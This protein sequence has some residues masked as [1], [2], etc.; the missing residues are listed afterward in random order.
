LTF[1][2]KILLFNL[3]F[4]DFFVHILLHRRRERAGNADV[5]G[6]SADISGK[7]ADVFCISADI[8]CKNADVLTRLLD[9]TLGV[10]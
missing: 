7:S 1:I 3:D 10:G 9:S 2:T 4:C 5:S 8:F 6:I